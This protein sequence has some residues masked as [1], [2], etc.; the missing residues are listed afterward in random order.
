MNN[1]KNTQKLFLKK[2]NFSKNQHHKE[3]K[4][5]KKRIIYL[6]VFL[7][8]FLNTNFFANLV[9]NRESSS[10]LCKDPIPKEGFYNNTFKDYRSDKTVLTKTNKLLPILKLGF[11]YTNTENLR[12]HHQIA[13]SF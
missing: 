3:D 12:L 10:E 6:I 5:Y 2:I 9:P 4:A 7:S 8:V 11:E 1:T 13:I